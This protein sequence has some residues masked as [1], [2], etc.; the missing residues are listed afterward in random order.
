MIHIFSYNISFPLSSRFCHIFYIQHVYNYFFKD[1]SHGLAGLRQHNFC[2]KLIAYSTNTNPYQNENLD[3]MV[4]HHIQI[5]FHPVQSSNT[6][7]CLW[8]ISPAPYR[9]TIRDFINVWLDQIMKH[10]HCASSSLKY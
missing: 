2:S 6:I 1:S 3:I 7:T 9:H 8:Q 10:W 5:G 4:Y